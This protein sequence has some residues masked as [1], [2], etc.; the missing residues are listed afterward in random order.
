MLVMA[1]AVLTALPAFALARRRSQAILELPASRRIDA[2][3]IVGS[4][5][6]GVGWGIAGFCPGPAIVSLGMG[7]WQPVLFVAAMLIGRA[8]YEVVEHLRQAS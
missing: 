4:L 1:A 8:A 7:Q 3:L 6:F 5:I 2:R